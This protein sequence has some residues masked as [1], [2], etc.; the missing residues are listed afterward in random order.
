MGIIGDSKDLIT[1]YKENK[2][3]IKKPLNYLKEHIWVRII[4]IVLVLA[5]IIGVVL[6]RINIKIDISQVSINYKEI[7]LNINDTAELNATVLLSNNKTY[8]KVI[9]SSNNPDVVSVDKS[10]KITANKKGTAEITAQASRFGKSAAAVCTVNVN[11]A[12]T[13]YS[14]S[15]STDEALTNEIVKV[16]VTTLPEDN[17]TNINIYAI[18]P[19]GEEFVRKLSDSG[20]YFYTETGTWKIYAMIEN[21]EGSYIGTKPEEIA[22]LEVSGKTYNSITEFSGQ[23]LNTENGS[24][25]GLFDW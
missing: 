16:Y 5:V 3:Q 14:I 4:I 20:Y 24:F 21:S 15:L 13:G 10:G 6:F 22:Y 1:I 25:S 18:A 12:P 19:S 23:L 17:V 2:E 11:T 7:T 8:N 9:W